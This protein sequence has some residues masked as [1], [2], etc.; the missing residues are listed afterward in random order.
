MEVLI[1]EYDTGYRMP[2]V[3]TEDVVT[4]VDSLRKVVHI[5]PQDYLPLHYLHADRRARAAKY[6]RLVNLQRLNR[7]KKKRA[8]NNRA[9]IARRKNRS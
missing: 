2:S 7:Y 9:R 6:D 8:R 1:V 4:V 5:Q 3:R